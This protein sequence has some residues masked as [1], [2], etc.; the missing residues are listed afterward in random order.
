MV[1]YFIHGEVLEDDDAFAG[2][3][4]DGLFDYGADLVGGDNVGVIGD[5]GAVV[6]GEGFDSTDAGDVF[7]KRSEKGG[8]AVAFDA[9][10]DAVEFFSAGVFVQD[11][12]GG[13]LGDGDA[14]KVATE[15]GGDN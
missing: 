6:G 1:L 10:Y 12:I 2:V 15:K 7:K 13:G 14:E 3:E 4:F 9:L 11:S 8:S 5:D